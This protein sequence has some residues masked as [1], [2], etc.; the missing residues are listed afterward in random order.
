VSVHIPASKVEFLDAMI[1]RSGKST[2]AYLTEAGL[3]RAVREAKAAGVAIPE[4][5]A[6]DTL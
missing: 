4:S 2:S 1:V 6:A 5:I 3:Q